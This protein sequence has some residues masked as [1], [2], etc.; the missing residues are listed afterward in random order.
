M[1]RNFFCYLLE[2]LSSENLKLRLVLP[3]APSPRITSLY[4][5]NSCSSSLSEAEGWLT[6]SLRTVTSQISPPIQRTTSA[7]CRHASLTSDHPLIHFREAGCGSFEEED[8]PKPFF[9]EESPIILSCWGSHLRLNNVEIAIHHRTPIY[10]TS[11]WPCAA[12]RIN[13]HPSQVGS[14]NM[15]PYCANDTRPIAFVSTHD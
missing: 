14:S 13:L 4:C 12:A 10:S 11:Y 2:N 6:I 5:R 8:R 7:T 3:T 9:G 1:I 15:V